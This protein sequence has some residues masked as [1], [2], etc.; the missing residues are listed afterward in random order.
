MAWRS[1]LEQQIDSAGDAYEAV[2]GD[3]PEVGKLESDREVFAAAALRSSLL[4]SD[5]RLT[6]L[7][8]RRRMGALASFLCGCAMRGESVTRRSIFLPL[9]LGLASS[10]LFALL[11]VSTAGSAPGTSC[12]AAEKAQRQAVLRAYQR[13]MSASRNAYFKTHKQ[14]S[15]RAAFVK[16]QHAKL[17]SL[18]RAAACVVS[19]PVPP[20]SPLPPTGPVPAPPPGPNEFFTFDSGITAADEDEIKG[21]VA[22]AV[23]DEAAL[24]GVPISAV[25]TFVSTN[26]G[27]L[28]DQECR[29]LQLRDDNCVQ[30]VQQRYAGG[31]SGEAGPGGL[32]LNWAAPSWRYDAGQNQK[33]TAHEL[34]HVFQYQLDKVSVNSGDDSHVPPGG[35]AWLL[36]GSAETVGYRVAADRRLVASSAAGEISRAKQISTP[37]SSLERY[38]DIQ[39]PNVYSLFHVAV[40]HLVTITPAG[41]PALTTYFNVIGGGMAWQDAFRAAF[42]MSVEAYYANFAAYRAGL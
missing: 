30:H 40:D 20:A 18:S 23:Q 41:V 8:G 22:Y 4:S 26:P 7:L 3:G 25:T 31:G 35:P 24:L 11:G 32:F 29:F 36:E 5:P 16:A 42:G 33:I 2:S 19:Q 21:D 1:V 34:F 39:I 38:A 6:P 27:W 37:L 15:L 28:A 14:E 10:L 13:T 12:T 9:L 17:A